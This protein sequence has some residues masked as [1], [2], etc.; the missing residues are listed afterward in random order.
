MSAHDERVPIDENFPF[1][2][3]HLRGHP[4]VHGL[5]FLANVE[6]AEQGAALL[7]PWTIPVV[8]G[9]APPLPLRGV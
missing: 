6:L 3:R 2:P 1:E 5:M 8:D 4:H 9:E 7:L